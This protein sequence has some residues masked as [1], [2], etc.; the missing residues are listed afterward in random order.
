MT[1]LTLK[2]VKRTCKASAT[3]RTTHG[4]FTRTSEVSK[5]LSV[6]HVQTATIV[7]QNGEEINNRWSS[8]FLNCQR[9]PQN[10]AATLSKLPYQRSR[11]TDPLVS[12]TN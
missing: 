3:A 11:A 8:W 5:I 2:L 1:E 12:T 4:R 10:E 6:Q 9:A 7:L